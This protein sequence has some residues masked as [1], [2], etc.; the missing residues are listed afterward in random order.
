MGKSVLTK[1]I[2]CLLTSVPWEFH[3][4][5]TARARASFGT[6]NRFPVGVRSLRLS[7]FTSYHPENDCVPF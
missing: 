4:V 1:C 3:S 6:W 5:E 7:R 2:E